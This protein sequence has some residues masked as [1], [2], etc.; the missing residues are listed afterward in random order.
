MILILSQA[1]VSEN[2][3]FT[4]YFNRKA[5]FSLGLIFFKVFKARP[6]VRD[7]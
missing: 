6:F 1:A 4:K 5:S 7:K 3:S 2:S